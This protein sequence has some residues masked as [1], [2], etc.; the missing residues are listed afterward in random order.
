MKKVIIFVILV[1][2]LGIGIRACH[3]QDYVNTL[4]Y[5]ADSAQIFISSDSI[6]I[7]P[8]LYVEDF[9][10]LGAVVDFASLKDSLLLED[11]R[12]TV[13]SKDNPGQSIQLTS[14]SAVIHP[15][16]PNGGNLDR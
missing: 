12:V 3:Q 11:L 1:A 13:H 8:Y 7:A 9:N 14:V 6:T 2:I 5:S 10:T 4:K 15:V 16:V